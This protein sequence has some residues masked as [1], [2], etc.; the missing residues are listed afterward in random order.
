MQA[1]GRHGRTGFTLIELL[2]VLLIVALLIAVVPPML[3]RSLPGSEAKAAARELVAALRATRRHAAIE[4]KSSGMLLDVKER[5][6]RYPGNQGTGRLPKRCDLALETARSE[7]LDK[8]RGYIR[9]W[10]TGGSSGGRIELDCGSQRLA[11]TVAWLT[12]RVA[13]VENPKDASS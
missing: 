4:H 11:V 6:F 8:N 7:L 5:T 10:P 1:R 9:F 2:V 12:G 13:I 3:T